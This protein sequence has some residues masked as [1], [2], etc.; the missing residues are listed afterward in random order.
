MTRRTT[1]SDDM[2]KHAERAYYTAVAEFGIDSGEAYVARA[3]L[4]DLKKRQRRQDNAPA[5][6]GD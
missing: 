2:L 4:S 3:H 5:G 6:A 1:T